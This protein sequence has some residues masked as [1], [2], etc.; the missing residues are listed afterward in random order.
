MSEIL[1]HSGWD[2]GP[3]SLNIP[4]Y[5]ITHKNQILNFFFIAH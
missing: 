5:D 4:A 2:P 1:A 3:V